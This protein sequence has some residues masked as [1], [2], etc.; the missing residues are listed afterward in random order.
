MQ[1]AKTWKKDWA[2]QFSW[3]M[4]PTVPRWEKNGWAQAATL[5]ISA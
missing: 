4:T 5:K 2:P 1:R 3:K